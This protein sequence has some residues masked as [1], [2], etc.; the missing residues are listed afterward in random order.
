MKI[1]ESELV[2]AEE[3]LKKH[4]DRIRDWVL[5]DIRKC[6]RLN[7]DNK[8]FGEGALVGTFIL[9]CCAIDYFGGLY[10][11]LSKTN[12]RMES[13]IT[14]Y[15]NKYGKYNAEKIYDLRWSLVHYYSPLYFAL[16]HL[17][18]RKKYHLKQTNKGCLLHLISCVED[19]EN[20]VD[21]YIRNLKI[22]PELKIKAF[23]YYKKNPVLQPIE[24]VDIIF[25][26]EKC[27]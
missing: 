15:L 18:E 12:C 16:E 8:T 27:E 1:D 23:R 25:T 22:T 3:Y 20:A 6:C 13:F 4:I 19:L 7:K 11:N 10:S 14:D 17:P 21:D 5:G 9:W 2:F 26:E 24:P